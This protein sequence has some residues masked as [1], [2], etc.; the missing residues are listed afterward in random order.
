MDHRNTAMIFL[1]HGMTS[2]VLIVGKLYDAEKIQKLNLPG[3][4]H[5]ELY[6]A[7]ACNILGTSGW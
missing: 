3:L 5:H 6:K 4:R 1:H 2:M 7:A